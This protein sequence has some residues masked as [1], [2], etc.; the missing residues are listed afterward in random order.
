MK[1]ATC[2]IYWYKKSMQLFGTQID[3][4]GV[5]RGKMLRTFAHN[6]QKP[7]KR[8]SN[9]YSP[10]RTHSPNDQTPIKTHIG[11]TQTIK[12]IQNTLIIRCNG[13]GCGWQPFP[14]GIVQIFGVQF[15]GTLPK[16][17]LHLVFVATSRNVQLFD[18]QFFN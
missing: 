2:A 1:R 5:G 16:L 3:L 18:V 9:S 15:S 4:K 14:N 8:H 10:T 17:K 12:H 7:R 11:T 6:S 13:A